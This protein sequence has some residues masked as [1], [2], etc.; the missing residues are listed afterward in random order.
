MPRRPKVPAKWIRCEADRQAIKEG[1]WFHK[2]AG[3]HVC[4]FVET[5]CVQ[6]KDRWKDEP[7]K[8]FDWERDFLMRLFGWK[9]ADGTRRFKTAY[10]EIAKKNGKS[11]L[12]SC[13]ALYFLVSEGVGAPLIHLNACD[14]DQAAI[15]FEET[16]NMI[17]ASPELSPVLKIVNSKADRRV[18]YEAENGAIVANSKVAGS[19]DGFGP[20][21][22]IFDELHRQPDRALWNVY[23]YAGAA[24]SEFLRISLTTAGEDESGVWHEQRELSEEIANG[25]NLNIRHLGVVY[26]AD[27]S[28]DIDDPAT[29][30][31]ANPSMGLT[32]KEHEFKE[33]LADA[34]RNPVDLAEFMRLRLNIVVRAEQKLF[35]RGA[36]EACKTPHSIP[37]KGQPFWIGLDLASVDDLAAMA[38]VWRGPKG[39]VN[40]SIKFW[41]PEKNIVELEQK[42]QQDYR[43][44]AN[45]GLITLTPGATIDYKWIRKEIKEQA[46]AGRLQKLLSDP[47]RAQ[48][49]LATLQ[50][51]DGLPVEMIP[52]RIS[53]LAPP[54]SELLRLVLAKQFNHGDHPILNWMAGNAI[55]IKDSNNNMMLSK[56]KSGKKIDGLA[57]I[58]NGLAGLTLA[59]PPKAS[60]YERRGAIAV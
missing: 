38:C 24:R 19:K 12:L 1:C 6:S 52:Q 33:E 60:V 17:R 26:R 23:K 55:A 35:K 2:E 54:T 30:R 5:F 22:V 7:V 39:E 53:H 9:N 48:E 37:L 34:K 51:E 36:W 29:W 32:I 11:L 56:E 42:H 41:L 40:A 14:R 13:L 50:D 15:I 4:D 49:L 8:L 21:H 20:S 27:P 44:W 18:I 43:V 16:A 59:P 31:K 3:E 58:V 10:L 47:W 25:T 45:G 28:D 57:A 46:K